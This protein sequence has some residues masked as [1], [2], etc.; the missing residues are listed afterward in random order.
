M[1]NHGALVPLLS[2]IS[3]G[4]LQFPSLRFNP[5]LA[6]LLILFPRV[7]TT[8]RLPVTQHPFSSMRA[9]LIEQ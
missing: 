2:S 1:A 3:R 5:S 8:P 9:R 6:V 7:S 4:E